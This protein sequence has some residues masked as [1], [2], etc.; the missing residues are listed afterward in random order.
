MSYSTYF[1][2]TCSL[3]HK[4]YSKKSSSSH[5]KGIDILYTFLLLIMNSIL[6]DKFLHISML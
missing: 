1:G 4:E 2:T 5:Y 3:F 6:I